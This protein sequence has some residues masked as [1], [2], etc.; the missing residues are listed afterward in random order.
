MGDWNKVLSILKEGGK[1]INIKWYMTQ[2]YFAKEECTIV[3]L[4]IK[5]LRVSQ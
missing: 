4:Q 3:M 5:D 1:C 2:T